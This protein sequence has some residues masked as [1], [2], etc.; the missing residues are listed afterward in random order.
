VPFW[1]TWRL[2]FWQ[3]N[4]FA[5]IIWGFLDRGVEQNVGW[6][7]SD[8]PCYCLSSYVCLVYHSEHISTVNTLR[9]DF[10]KNTFAVVYA[11]MLKS[12]LL[13]LMT[14]QSISAGSNML[15][16]LPPALTFLFHALFC[17]H[18]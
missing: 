10:F 6:L 9:Y 4:V 2:S 7:C 15:N 5:D 18:L 17:V 13:L 16:I 1:T 12:I 11:T 8:S 3:Y 14:F